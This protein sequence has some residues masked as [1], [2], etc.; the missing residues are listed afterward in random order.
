MANEKHINSRIQHKHDIEANW[1]KATTFIPKQGELII[2]D[3]DS[4]FGYERVKI[5]D[6]ITNVSTLP[7][8]T[9][10]EFL[11]KTGDWMTGPFGLTEDIGYGINLPSNGQEGQV[12]FLQDD[13]LGV[14][15][16]LPTK[17]DNGKFLR[18]VNGQPKWVSIP[19]AESSSF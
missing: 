16:P 7:F 5:G 14:S 17:E 9:D 18:V 12:F 8:I 4:N 11:K 13:G 19:T 2:Y 1:L 10:G 6:G 3:I 15:I